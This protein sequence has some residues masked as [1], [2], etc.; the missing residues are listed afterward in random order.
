VLPIKCEKEGKVMI[1]ESMLETAFA[2]ITERTAGSNESERALSFKDL[3]DEVAT[4]LEMNEDERKARIGHFYTDLS[5]DGRFVELTDNTWDLRSNHT[6]DKVHIDVNDV[7]SDVE[8]EVE[9]EDEEEKAFIG[10]VGTETGGT[11]DGE[12]EKP[13][14]EDI[15]SLGIKKE[16]IGL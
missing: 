5:I 16:D 11:G 1:N 15:E 2:V 8:E 4:R 6:Y 3:Y 10:E 7:Y 14:T 9:E 13:A 12:E